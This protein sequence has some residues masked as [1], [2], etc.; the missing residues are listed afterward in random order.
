M[1]HDPYAEGREAYDAGQPETANPY[2]TDD[3]GDEEAI[4]AWLDG[5][6]AAAEEAEDE[7]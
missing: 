1:F 2:D 4:L 7:A 6:N 5:W 3:C